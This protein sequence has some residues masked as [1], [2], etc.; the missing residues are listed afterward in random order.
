MR[1]AAVI[2]TVLQG[3]GGLTVGLLSV[4]A[5]SPPTCPDRGGSYLC[6]NPSL[7]ST[8]V[9]VVIA[10]V[11]IGA[12]VSGIGCGMRSVTRMLTLLGI[13]SG[14]G[15]LALVIVVHGASSWS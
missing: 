15:M 14:M 8:M 7:Q 1:V 2:Y 12:I 13:G 10:L 9:W 11:L 6:E 3:L 4:F 5:F